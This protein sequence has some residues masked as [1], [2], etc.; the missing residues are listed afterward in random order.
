MDVVWGPPGSQSEGEQQASHGNRFR[1]KKREGKKAMIAYVT[2]GYLCWLV[3]FL[4][5]FTSTYV[6]VLN[7]PE[8]IAQ[9]R[10]LRQRDDQSI[11]YRVV[12][13]CALKKEY[14]LQI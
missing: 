1:K 6:D 7:V 3:Y 4:L 5:S 2:A 8:R 12:G 14:R 9:Y 13:C 10:S 11:G